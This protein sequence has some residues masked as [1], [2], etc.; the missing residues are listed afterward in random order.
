MCIIKAVCN[1]PGWKVIFLEEKC[2]V[3]IQWVYIFL[4]YK[5][6]DWIRNL[7]MPKF[8]LYN[9]KETKRGNHEMPVAL[10]IC[11]DIPSW[12]PGFGFESRSQPSIL[13]KN[14]IDTHIS[15]RFVKLMWIENNHKRPRLFCKMYKN[16][17][18]IL[19]EHLWAVSK[20][21][22]VQN[23]SEEP[24][25]HKHHWAR[26]MVGWEKGYHN[27]RTVRAEWK[28]VVNV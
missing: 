15:H 20:V 12:S 19:V 8:K 23:G 21:R 6:N 13:F 28:L 14:L 17:H 7:L 10:W 2:V 26:H 9:N 11:R 5:M 1:I 25:E 22:S 3:Q 16:Y 27:V 18:D 24:R 4:K